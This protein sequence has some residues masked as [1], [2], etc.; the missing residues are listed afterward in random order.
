ML[1]MIMAIKKCLLHCKKYNICLSIKCMFTLISSRSRQ[2][3]LRNASQDSSTLCASV[4]GSISDCSIF[5][6][7]TETSPIDINSCWKS[8][9]FLTNY[10]SYEAGTKAIW[11]L[12]NWSVLLGSRTQPQNRVLI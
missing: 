3:T 4:L 5:S 6:I 7:E 9:Y 11:S 8:R 12:R 2:K 10:I 1:Q